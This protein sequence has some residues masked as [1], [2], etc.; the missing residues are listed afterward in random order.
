MKNLFNY[1]SN[2]PKDKLLHF[3]YGVLLSAPLVAF[4]TAFMSSLVVILIALGKEIYDDFSGTGNIQVTDL[5]FT[6]APVVI[7]NVVK[8]I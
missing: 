7:M 5:V 4:T 3:F 2:I 8:Y 6:I 1:L